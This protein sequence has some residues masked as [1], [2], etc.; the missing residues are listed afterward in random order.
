MDTGVPPVGTNPVNNTNKLPRRS[1]TTSRRH[2]RPT[3]A[4]LTALQCQRRH[5]LFR[6]LRTLGA[7]LG[8]TKHQKRRLRNPNNNNSGRRIPLIQWKGGAATT[9]MTL[10]RAAVLRSVQQHGPVRSRTAPPTMGQAW[11]PSR[12]TRPCNRRFLGSSINSRRSRPRNL[13]LHLKWWQ[14]PPRTVRRANRR[15]P[16]SNISTRPPLRRLTP[17]SG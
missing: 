12:P 1:G 16:P 13:R 3:P 10:G 15:L 2:C 17:A 7:R 9:S 6:R 14:P 11:L 8:A 4:V 5:L